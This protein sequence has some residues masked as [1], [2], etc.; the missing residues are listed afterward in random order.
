MVLLKHDKSIVDQAMRIDS[1]LNWSLLK[2]L[3]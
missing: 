1:T 3:T 2:I